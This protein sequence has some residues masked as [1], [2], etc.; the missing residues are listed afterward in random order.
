MAHTHSPTR[1]VS[2]LPSGADRQR[3][4]SRGICSSATSIAG[5]TPTTSA[6]KLRPSP[7]VT[8]TRSAPLDDVVIGQDVARRID[9]EPAAGAFARRARIVRVRIAGWV[10]ARPIGAARRGVDIDDRRVD[11]CGDRAKSTG[12][13][14][15]RR[16]RRRPSDGDLDRTASSAAGAAT[17]QRVGRAAAGA[18]PPTTSPSR[19]LTTAVSPTNAPACRVHDRISL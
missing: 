9:D 11:P 12:P 17:G 6:R 16:R 5:S 2:E 19:K 10:A 3:L 8:V 1:S 4:A 15:T 7:S 18:C 13:L 14:T